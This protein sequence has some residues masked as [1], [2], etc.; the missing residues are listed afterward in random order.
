MSKKRFA[1]LR[2][3]SVF[4]FTAALSACGNSDFFFGLEPEADTFEQSSSLNR[5]NTIDVLWVVDNSGSM[6]DLQ[7]N[8]ADNMNT[9]MGSF[10]SEGYDFQMAVTATD[11]W[12]DEFPP[13]MDPMIAKFRDGVGTTRTGVFV[14]TPQTVNPINTFITNFMQGIAGS[15][16]ERAFSSFRAALNSPLNAGFIRPGGYLS[17]IIVSDEEDFS[18]DDTAMNESYAQPTLHPI[19]DYVDFLDA[20]TGSSGRF[21]RYNVSTISIL[22]AACLAQSGGKIGTRLMELADATGGLKID[23]CSPTFANDLDMLKSYLLEMLTQFFLSRDPNVDTITVYVDGRVVPK[24]DKNGW[25]Y[26]ADINAVRFHGSEVPPE[27]AKI[28]VSYDPA[29]I[30]H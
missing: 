7:Q 28:G 13:P 30:K 20:A 15:G 3:V 21:R 16:D 1:L 29:S 4:S 18:H 23:V 24:D 5:I 27:G 11:A 9:F 6:A 17:V 26:H 10:L 19:Q 12:K 22:D 14:V 25:T 8:M 2:L